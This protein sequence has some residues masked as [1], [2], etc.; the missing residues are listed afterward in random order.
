M[1][2]LKYLRKVFN[3]TY[4]GV[5]FF[6]YLYITK[7]LRFNIVKVHKNHKYRTTFK[8]RYNIVFER[9]G[10]KMLLDGSTGYKKKIPHNIWS[11]V[12]K[13]GLFKL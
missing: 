11:Y 1:K 7:K 10:V 12:Y 6:E 3:D 2:L 5:H 9:F 8:Y 13:I 4:N